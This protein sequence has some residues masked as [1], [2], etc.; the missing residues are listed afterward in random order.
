M[1]HIYTRPT[2]IEHGQMT[3]LTQGPCACLDEGTSLRSA[4]N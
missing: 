2:I 1:K 4:A 3:T